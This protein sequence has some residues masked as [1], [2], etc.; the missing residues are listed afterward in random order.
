MTK[1]RAFLILFALLLLT[2]ICCFVI[3]GIRDRHALN[4]L[5]AKQAALTEY[6][7]VLGTPSEE[8]AA[9]NFANSRAAGL[10]DV[11]DLPTNSTFA[12]WAKEGIPYYWVLIVKSGEDVF[13]NNVY[14]RTGW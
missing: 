8:G 9:T 3:S 12:F 1:F 10:F 13:S 5:H 2:P 11:R 7:N 14:V 6:H 4:K